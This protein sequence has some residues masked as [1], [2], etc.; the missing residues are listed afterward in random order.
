MAQAGD[1][2]VRLESD[3]GFA[4][5]VAVEADGAAA[6]LVS[7]PDGRPIVE[8]AIAPSMARDLVFGRTYV[9]T[10]LA[11]TVRQYLPG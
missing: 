7:G 5:V 4:R 9:V 1:G 10:E 2:T 11:R 6:L 8:L 3:W